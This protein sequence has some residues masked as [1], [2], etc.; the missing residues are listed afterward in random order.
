MDFSKKYHNPITPMKNTLSIT[1]ATGAIALASLGTASAALTAK[2]AFD[3]TTGGLSGKGAAGG[4]WGGAWGNASANGTKDVVSGS[5]TSSVAS[6]ET[7][8][9]ASMVGA[10]GGSAAI[11]RT[12]SSSIT[13]GTYYVGFTFQTNTTSARTAGLSLF[14]GTATEKVLVGISNNEGTRKL[15]ISNGTFTD[16]TAIT[17]ANGTTN[18]MVLRVD[19]STTGNETLNLFVDQATEGTANATL[20]SINFGASGFNTFRLFAGGASTD[21]LQSAFFDEVRIGTTYADALVPEP[22]SAMLIGSFG[23][24]ALLRRRR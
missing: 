4:G 21:P 18:Q 19:M 24:L 10:S 14:D 6:G 7:G 11:Y 23:A 17:A 16:A 13:T 20:T 9:K 5:L 15:L 12:L 3:Y 2:D 1:F 22:S 8:N